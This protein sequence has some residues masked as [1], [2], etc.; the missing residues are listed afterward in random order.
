MGE[1]LRPITHDIYRHTND[2]LIDAAGDLM[3]A[4]P[5]SLNAAIDEIRQHRNYLRVA[6]ET[7]DD[8]ENYPEL[9][10]PSYL[11]V[12]KDILETAERLAGIPREGVR[13]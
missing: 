9:I 3:Q 7:V 5:E 6:R 2:E 1:Q 8:W 11:A 10:N 12:V 4:R 13:E